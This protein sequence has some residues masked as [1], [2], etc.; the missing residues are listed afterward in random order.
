MK[1]K[2]KIFTLFG[3]GGIHAGKI[4]KCLSHVIYFSKYSFD[5]YAS[6][7]QNPKLPIKINAQLLHQTVKEIY[8]GEYSAVYFGDS[9]DAYLIYYFCKKKN[10][11]IKPF[12]INEVD[13]F[14][15]AQIV[16]KFLLK[17]YKN[18]CFEEFITSDFCKWMFII[19]SREE[20]Y[21]KLGIK[22]EN[23]FYIPA[24]TASIGFFFPDLIKE[25]NSKKVVPSI[26]KEV[27][28]M[29]GKVLAIGSH[30]RDYDF[31][32]QT[33][34]DLKIELHIICN[35]NLYKPIKV[36]NVYWHNSLPQKDYIEA[37]KNAKYIIVP[38]R[39]TNRSAGQ[40][41]C[42]IPMHLG[43]IVIAAKVDSLKEFIIPGKTGF[44]YNIGNMQSLTK[45]INYVESNYENLKF[46]G[47]EAKKNEARLS[48]IA[49]KNIQRFLNSL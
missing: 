43:K 37:I 27:Q 12:F 13:L 41:S 30:E 21:T 18:D 23:L 29:K 15:R 31:L 17:S 24:A 2:I 14:E 44:F 34:K 1:K 19:S 8:K 16:R 49:S 35:L 33:V 36:G 47:E 28:E 6:F 25:L 9:C 7:T 3:D 32:V 5:D 10:L 40:M 26:S 42:S 48:L 22:K 39:K 46:I 38:L 45:I 11:P 20:I 4:T